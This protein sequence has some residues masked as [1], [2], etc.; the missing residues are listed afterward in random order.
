M[1]NQQDRRHFARVTFSGVIELL[2]DGQ[3]WRCE[4]VDISLK[5]ALINLPEHCTLN[6]HEPFE[7]SLQ[8]EPE[9]AIHMTVGWSHGDGRQIGVVCQQIDVQSVGHLRRLIELNTG[10]PVAAERE[11]HMLGQAAS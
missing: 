5:G 2:Q 1:T 6:A 9:T 10:D 3:G 4:L 8:L 11:L 7:L